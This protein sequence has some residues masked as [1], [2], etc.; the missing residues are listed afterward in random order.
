MNSK[1]I[2][3]VSIII[4]TYN[5]AKFISKA[6]QSI[7]DQTFKKW[8]AIIIDNNSTDDTDKIL[9][10]FSDNRIKCLKIN[11]NGVIAKSRNL[12][13]KSAKGEWIAFLDSDDWWTNDKLKH[14]L[15]SIDENVDFIYHELEIIGI[16]PRFNLKR[17]NFKGR[18]LNKPILKDLLFSVIK[19]GNAIG[20][21]SVL[22]RKKLL[23]KIGGINENK[24]LVASED[25]NTWLK[26]AELTDKFK[27]IKKSLGFYLVHD[28]SA[29]KKDLSIPHRQAVIDFM[30][31]F[32]EKQKQNF[33][34]K[35]KY[36]SANYKIFM[37]NY[38]KARQDLKFVIK[39]GS[40]KFK[41]KSFLKILII[42]FK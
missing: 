31:L 17:K 16:K 23:T 30:N 42:A 32:N 11:N 18:Q 6:L 37:K 26:I 7:I 8:E 38:I 1:L 33:E 19:D 40:F 24:N 34:V 2:P 22:V 21:S 29:Q 13:I 35:L 3:I 4:P 28:A 25:Y 20:N 12:G 36:M 10:K 27:F 5:H 9:K 14:C 15:D 39:N 41:I